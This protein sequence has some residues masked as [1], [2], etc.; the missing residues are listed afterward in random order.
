VRIRLLTVLL[1]AALGLAG[2]R[3]L[4]HARGL[5]DGAAY[6]LTRAWAGF[7]TRDQG[8]GFADV[9]ATWIVPRIVCNRPSSSV[10]F[11]VGLGGATRR[12][13][14]L[15]QIGTSADCSDRAA[16]SYSAWYE[17]YPAPA[18]A[19]AVA[20]R[21][22]ETITADVRVTGDQIAI[23]LVNDSTEARFARRLTAPAPETDSAE[24]IVEAPSSCLGPS[25]APLPF[26]RFR[27][28][29]FASA[30]ATLG[31]RAYA[32]GDPRLETELFAFARGGRIAARP[33]PATPWR[34]AGSVLG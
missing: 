17:A 26:A 3:E 7:V 29:T 19:V 27:R 8:S 30:T 11:W 21:P 16:A 12:S 15:E 2:A 13:G 18:V 9:R 1:A 20:V 6:T 31:D 22:G 28:V 25:C 32:L 10:A 24:W 33:L 14:A 5:S 34:A 23:S 4:A